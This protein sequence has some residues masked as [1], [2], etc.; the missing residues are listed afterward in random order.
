MTVFVI[1]GRRVVNIADLVSP[2]RVMSSIVP[3]FNIGEW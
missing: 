2:N 3:D 1:P